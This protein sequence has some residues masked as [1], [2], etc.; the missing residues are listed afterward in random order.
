MTNITLPFQ[1]YLRCMGA[2]NPQRL[3]LPRMP[4]KQA[5]WL[6]KR[7]YTDVS[8]KGNISSSKLGSRD[9]Q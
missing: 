4:L 8:L 3:G 6:D 2:A 5:R 1:F 7:L 9:S